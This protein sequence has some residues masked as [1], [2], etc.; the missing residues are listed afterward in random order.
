MS[1]L[2]N[3]L[4]NLPEDHFSNF[5]PP[6]SRL[7]LKIFGKIVVPLFFNLEI[8]GKG[9]F[10]N[11]GP[12]IIVGNHEGALEAVLMGSFTP[13]NVEMLAGSEFPQ[14]KIVKVAKALYGC[15]P[16]KRMFMDKEALEL[17]LYILQNGG[18]IG[19]FP[20]GGVWNV[21]EMEPKLGAAWLS[22]YSRVPIL[23]VAFSG[24]KGA[25][26]K[27]LQFKR[28]TLKMNVGEVMPPIDDVSE[29]NKKAALKEYSQ[30]IWNVIDGLVPEKS[31]IITNRK[32]D[33]QIH[34]KDKNGKARNLP[35]E[36]KLIYKSHLSQ[37]LHNPGII[38][39][40]NNNLQMPVEVLKDLENYHPA[41]EFYEATAS[42]LK[43]LNNKNPYLLLY[44][45]GIDKGLKMKKGIEEL[46]KL[47]E[48]AKTNNLLIRITPLYEYD[49]P[50]KQQHVIKTK[51]DEFGKWI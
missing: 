19:I 25:W 15:I 48:W 11:E 20:E 10:P 23:P 2:K 42:I 8:K 28:P 40:L 50:E 27:A 38:K 6:L 45:V 18:V 46:S 33:L 4:R 35:C 51:Q 36:L 24:S 41:R 5:S 47:A 34:L 43:Y 26:H 30:N 12:L 13:L 3:R 14:E 49:L 29:D 44:R 37:F 31:Q 21:G 32:F 39:L 7:F 1:K 17:S 22:Y 16:V 9:N